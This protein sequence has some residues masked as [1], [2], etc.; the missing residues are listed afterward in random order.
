MRLIARV[1][2]EIVFFNWEFHPLYILH[3]SE[4]AR[5]LL[6][7]GGKRVQVWREGLKIDREGRK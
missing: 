6:G 1:D 7:S 3:W 4:M 2:M 5:K